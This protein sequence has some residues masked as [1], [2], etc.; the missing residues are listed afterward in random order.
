MLD[1]S[2]WNEGVRDQV[3]HEPIEESRQR[4][5][6]LDHGRN[7]TGQPVVI[8]A[9]ASKQSLYRTGNSI[10]IR[11]RWLLRQITLGNQDLQNAATGTPSWCWSKTSHHPNLWWCLWSQP[12]N[13][14]ELVVL[15]T[16]LTLVLKHS[17][18]LGGCGA[19]WVGCSRQVVLI[20]DGLMIIL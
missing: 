18:G 9:D 14:L 15:R 20:Q 3:Y 2:S 11:E 13:M 8:P 4:H 16:S 5:G 17:T 10:N 7:A 6:L 19:G 12:F 1:G